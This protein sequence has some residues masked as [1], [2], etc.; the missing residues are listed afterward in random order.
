MHITHFSRRD[1]LR[2][3]AAGV[4]GSSVSGW[5]GLLADRAAAAAEQGVK[6]K[7]CILLWMAGG[8]A[9]SHNFDLKSGSEYKAISTAV[10]GVQISE[11]LPR[12]AKTM[13]DLALLRSMR[14]GDGNH[15]TAT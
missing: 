10:P 12:L 11:H 13:K 15:Q 14:T 4:L 2:L 1:L 6:H 9:Q 5:F 7:S 3:S 8:P